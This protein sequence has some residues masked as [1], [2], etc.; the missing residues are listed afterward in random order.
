MSER[1]DG[2]AQAHKHWVVVNPDA[3]TNGNGYDNYLTTAAMT[4]VE[5]LT[6]HDGE[7]NHSPLNTILFAKSIRDVNKVYKILQE[8]LRNRPELLRKVRKYVSAELNPS[9]KREIYEG[10]KK[11]TL[12]G[13]VSTNAL[14]AGIDIGNLDS[15]II[16]G[17]PFSVMGMR[18]MAGRVGRHQEGLVV[19]IP[20]PT[21][22]I[23]QYYRLNQRLLL[24]QPPEVFVVDPSNPYIT[25]KHI[26]AAAESLGWLDQQELSIFGPRA[27]EIVEQ[28][29]KDKVMAR[30]GSRFTGTQR[31]FSNKSDSYAISGVRSAAQ[32]PYTICKAGSGQ[33]KM[34]A[35]C[36]DNTDRKKCDSQV[37]IRIS[38]MRIGICHPGA[39]YEGTDGTPYRAI[40][41]DDRRRA[42][43]VVPL[44]DDSLERTFAE[45]DVSII[46]IG[47]P[48]AKKTLAGGVELYV[49]DVQVT[50]SYTG[51]YTY[52][53]V[54]KSNCRKCR[55][56][57]DASVAVCP[58]CN[59][60]TSRA[61][62]PI[63]T[64]AAGFS[65]AL[66]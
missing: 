23:D 32:V 34:S 47:D 28:A 16:A 40:S 9:E 65:Q 39:I 25:K 22:A 10:L 44:A 24:E 20:Q 15:C 53:L 12:I 66:R 56:E 38:K 31:S 49:G 46:I 43:Q 60:K 14:E 27:L 59:R 3:L 35:N 62:A 19:Y 51:Y 55:R 41:L 45:E 36:M 33:C 13:V 21:S 42:I 7:N 29:I 54:P 64:Q 17:F 37:T 5:L 6:A 30:N 4:M 58:T 26:N 48:K 1:D 57:Y 2:S 8:N 11:G 18:Q 52:Q 61:Y 50:R 63:K